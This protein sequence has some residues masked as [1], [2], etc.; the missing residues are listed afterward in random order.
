MIIL[1]IIILFIIFYIIIY[2]KNKKKIKIIIFSSN[3][4]INLLSDTFYNYFNNMNNNN[5]ELRNIKNKKEYLNNL[6]KCFYNINIYEKNIINNAINIAHHKLNTI[7]CPGF[8]PKKLDKIPWKIGF[9]NLYNYEF[10]LPHTHKDI[11]L[12]NRNNIY[13]SELIIILMHERIHVYQ[14]LFPKD[15]KEYLYHHNFINIGKKTDIDRVN[16]DTDEYKYSRNN[17]I[18]ECTINNNTI[19]CTKN[20][21]KYEHPFEYMAYTLSES[22]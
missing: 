13:D 5:L 18:Y 12:L 2:Q 14:R 4:I 19:K 3:D 9:S 7:E 17:I 11:I 22:I 20:N 10:G 8:Y 15:I 21:S 16:P 1:S 6:Y